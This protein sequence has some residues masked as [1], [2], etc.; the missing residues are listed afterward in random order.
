MNLP[1][2]FK[3]SPVWKKAM[4]LAIAINHSI[5]NFPPQEKHHQGLCDQL[6]QASI[7]VTSRIAESHQPLTDSPVD[8]L[9]RA[10]FHLSETEFLLDVA[11]Y[12][13]YIQEDERVRL[14]IGASDIREMLNTLLKRNGRHEY[15]F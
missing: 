10:R 2:N 1:V 11:Y 13:G 4:D 6:L 8:M 3:K 12:L 5:R 14:H 7:R 15:T 9:L